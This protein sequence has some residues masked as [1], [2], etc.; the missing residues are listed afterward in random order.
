MS[1]PALHGIEAKSLDL[2]LPVIG[3][4]CMAV[5]M[6]TIVVL[7]GSPLWQAVRVVLVVAVCGGVAL[8]V[9][10]ASR[11]AAIP[12]LLLG[13]VAATAGGTIGITHLTD[14]GLSLKAAA[15]LV[16]FA[17]GLL[18]IFTSLG[19][20]CGQLEAGGV[21]WP[22]RLLLYWRGPLSSLWGPRSMPPTYPG[23]N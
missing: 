15:G 22:F 3:C 10:R 16:A 17:G 7:E 18:A 9:G 19:L 1:V 11:V 4:A 2:S 14:V 8:A 13:V 5:G 21:F 12:A 6:E 20:L 23:P